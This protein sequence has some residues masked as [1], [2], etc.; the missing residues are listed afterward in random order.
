MT[1]HSWIATPKEA[2]K[3]Q[4]KVRKQVKICPLP[5]GK[6]IKYIAG[7][8]VSMNMFSNTLYAGFVLLSFPEL[9]VIDHAVV[10]GEARFPYI[11]GLLSFREIPSLL[12]AWKELKIKPDMIMVDGVGIAHPRRLGIASHLGVILDLPTIGCAK[13]VLIGVY[14]EPKMESGSI[15]YMNDPKTSEIIGAAVRTKKNVK[16][17]FISPGHKITLEESVVLVLKCIRKHRMPEPTRQAHNVMNEHRILG[18]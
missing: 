14:D 10:K 12:K 1:K 13:N 8:D 6:Q 15:S 9:E 4:N 11:P 18:Q 2:I 16:P 17:M 3:I 5:D 7:A